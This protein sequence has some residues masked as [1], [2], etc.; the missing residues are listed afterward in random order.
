MGA[1]GLPVVGV[2]RDYGNPQSQWMVSQALF[3]RCWPALTP[4]GIALYG[5]EST[6]WNRVR[7]DLAQ[8]FSLDDTALTDRRE[9]RAAGLAVFD[10]TFTVTRALNALTLL[11]AGIGIFCAISAI[12]HHRVAQQALLA[13]L[14]V[15]RVE[16]GAL[17]L[18][19]WS[20]LGVLCMALVWPFGTVLAGYLV[21]VVTP[22]AF[23]WSFALQPEWQH[24][25][26][27]ALLA[28][29]C[30]WQRCCRLRACCFSAS[31]R[32]QTLNANKESG[33]TRPLLHQGLQARGAPPAPR[34]RH[35]GAPS[36]G[37]AQAAVVSHCIFRQ[38]TARIPTSASSGGTSR[39]IYRMRMARPTAHNG[40]CSD[41]PHARAQAGRPTPGRIRRYTWRTSA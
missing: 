32:E 33:V 6:D 21:A 8:T 9:L 35:A 17:L 3:E 10:R 19:Q 28:A 31:V 25:P 18:L 41:W 5:P 13:S 29:A 40:P 30:C 11:V 2:Y 24:Y 23:G 27:L 39:P 34:Y 12:H 20:L 26:V 37:Y 14:G 16:R 36:G 22:I 1:G 38:I 4:A 7:Q 15:T